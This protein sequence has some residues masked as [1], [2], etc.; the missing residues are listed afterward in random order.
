MLWSFPSRT[1]WSCP[2]RTFWSFPS[3]VPCQIL[4]FTDFL[5][6]TSINHCYGVFPPVYTWSFP[7]RTFLEF[8]LP[9]ATL[10]II[11]ANSY[12]VFPPVYTWSFP[13]RTFWSFPSPMPHNKNIN[14]FLLVELCMYIAFNIF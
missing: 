10:Q 11:N 12:G 13:S 1:F 7:S 9:H 3:Y 2:S 4:E 6:H 8:S 14:P 5:C